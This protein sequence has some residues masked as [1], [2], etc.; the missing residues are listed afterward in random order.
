MREGLEARITVPEIP[1]RTFEGKIVR[2]SVAL[3]YSTRTLTTE[4]DVLNPAEP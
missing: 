2:N 3:P 4:I 1:D